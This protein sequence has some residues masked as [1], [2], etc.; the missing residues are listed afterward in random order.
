MAR[1]R[2]TPST[3][4]VVIVT[5]LCLLTIQL[6][7]YTVYMRRLDRSTSTVLEIAETTTIGSSTTST[8]STGTPATTSTATTTSPTAC[9]SM[10]VTSIFR[11][12]ISCDD[13]RC[14][15]Q[16][17]SNKFGV[18]HRQSWG[19]ANEL[20]QTWWHGHSCTTSPQPA[21][22]QLEAATPGRW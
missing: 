7:V 8:T 9:D 14:S 10:T 16:G 12:T 18:A 20:A 11:G 15:C 4:R 17:L 3:R 21:S 5:V 19:S 1:A 6:G 22:E 13:W 2:K